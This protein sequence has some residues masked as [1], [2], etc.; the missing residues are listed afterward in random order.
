MYINKKNT[1]IHLLKKKKNSIISLL[2]NYELDIQNGSEKL[3]E[4]LKYNSKKPIQE[5]KNKGES[6]VGI[7]AS[8]EPIGTGNPWLSEMPL[9]HQYPIHQQGLPRETL[10]GEG[11]E[12]GR[13]PPAPKDRHKGLSFIWILYIESRGSIR[14]TPALGLAD[15]G[16]WAA[17]G[18]GFV[19]CRVVVHRE[20]G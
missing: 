1:A 9:L 13:L 19:L 10:W 8:R 12:G 5:D 20:A 4:K 15:L 3:N 14:C 16:R 7:I 17:P 18:V 6:D 11:L 2:D